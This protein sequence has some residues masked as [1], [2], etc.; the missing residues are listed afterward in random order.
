MRQFP[1]RQ[2]LT[3]RRFLE[4]PRRQ[5]R[6]LQRVTDRTGSFDA[7]FVADLIRSFVL[8]FKKLVLCG[9]PHLAHATAV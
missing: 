5:R 9:V 1:E 8:S 7:S 6:V 3:S 2:R 4:Q